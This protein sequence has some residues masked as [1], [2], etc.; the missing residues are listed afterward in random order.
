MAKKFGKV[1][2]TLDLHERQWQCCLVRKEEKNGQYI[3]E[4]ERG[5]TNEDKSGNDEGNKNKWNSWM[6]LTGRCGI[7][8]ATAMVPSRVP[9]WQ[10]SVVSWL[11]RWDKVL[12]V[13]IVFFLGNKFSVQWIVKH[14]PASHVL[15]TGIKQLTKCRLWPLM[16]CL[17]GHGQIGGLLWGHLKMCFRQPSPATAVREVCLDKAWNK[18]FM[19]KMEKDRFR[20]QNWW[21]FDPLLPFHLPHPWW[22]PDFT[23]RACCFVFSA[24]LTSRCFLCIL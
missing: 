10:G 5:N 6:W 21:P 20:N 19:P 23:A 16:H 18:A 17:R 3:L 15:D 12:E 9:W 22:L 24:L 4:G 13:W 1:S 2:R 7:Y 8:L 14:V 11:R